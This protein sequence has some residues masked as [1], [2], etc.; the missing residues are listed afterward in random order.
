MPPL[1]P[2]Q[3]DLP[4]PPSPSPVPEESSAAADIRGDIIA[5]TIIG[6][7]GLFTIALWVQTTVIPWYK[8]CQKL[9]ALQQSALVDQEAELRGVVGIVNRASGEEISR[10]RDDDDGRGTS[11]LDLGSKV[12][13]S[14]MMWR[15][16]SADIA[17]AESHGIRDS[18]ATVGTVGTLLEV[19]EAIPM[20]VLRADPVLIGRSD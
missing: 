7:V 1:T 12:R 3:H 20:A 9:Y 10:G 18:Y 2:T 6:L 5:G 16:V 17:D 11:E 8:R 14:E 15:R 19:G 4:S 13:N